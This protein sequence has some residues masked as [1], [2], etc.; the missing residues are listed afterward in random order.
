MG[1]NLVQ[2]LVVQGVG[3]HALDAAQALV[4][5]GL[6]LIPVAGPILGKILGLVI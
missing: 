4:H 1:I 2:D 3:Q 6:K 5:A